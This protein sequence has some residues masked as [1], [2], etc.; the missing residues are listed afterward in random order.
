MAWYFIRYGSWP[1]TNTAQ[2]TD[3]VLESIDF[4]FEPEMEMEE[5]QGFELL[6]PLSGMISRFYDDLTR[7]PNGGLRHLAP[8]REPGSLGVAIPKDYKGKALPLWRLHLRPAASFGSV[9]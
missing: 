7:G 8:K 4:V 9:A 5:D 2:V 1:C 6:G 3:G